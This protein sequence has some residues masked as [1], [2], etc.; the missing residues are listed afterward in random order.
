MSFIRPL[1]RLDLVPAASGSHGECCESV[2]D[3]V[4]LFTLIAGKKHFHKYFP[5]FFLDESSFGY[6]RNRLGHL[7]SEDS[8]RRTY[9]RQAVHICCS[10]II[11]RAKQRPPVL[12]K[13]PRRGHQ[14]HRGC[15]GRVVTESKHKSKCQ[16]QVVVEF[17]KMSQWNGKKLSIDN[18][19]FLEDNSSMAAESNGLHLSKSMFQLSTSLK[20]SMLFGTTLKLST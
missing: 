6:L 9:K 17:E 4:T 3:P 13:R 11:W 7:L 19:W 2:V 10:C 14:G 16:Q 12:G 18:P 15:G 5:L 8:N 20:E 1:P